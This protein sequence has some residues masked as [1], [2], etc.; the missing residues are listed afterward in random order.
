MR[1]V[2]LYDEDNE[3]LLQRKPWKCLKMAAGSFNMALRGPRWRSG[4][5]RWRLRVP[6]SGGC[7]NMAESHKMFLKEI[8]CYYFSLPEDTDIFSYL[9]AS[10]CHVGAMKE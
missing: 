1:W 4:V 3:I 8:L 10:A 7:F 2:T 6:D 5:S 9:P